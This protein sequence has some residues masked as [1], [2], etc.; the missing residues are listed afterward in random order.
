[1]QIF[2]MPKARKMVEAY[3]DGYITVQELREEMEPYWGTKNDK[4][5]ERLIVE[6]ARPS[7]REILQEDG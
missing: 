6:M 1:M 5:T 3:Q 2:Q 4:E 7:K